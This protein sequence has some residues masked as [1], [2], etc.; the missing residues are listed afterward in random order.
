MQ[1]EAATQMNAALLYRLGQDL[2]RIFEN[3]HI[4]PDNKKA[5]KRKPQTH[6]A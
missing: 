2:V 3:A 4:V 6:A 5:A 1:T